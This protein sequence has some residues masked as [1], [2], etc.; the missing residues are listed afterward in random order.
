MLISCCIQLIHH[1][2]KDIAKEASELLILAFSYGPEDMTTDYAGALFESTKIALEETI[3]NEITSVIPVEGIVA[4]FARKSKQ[5]AHSILSFLL[6]TERIPEWGDQAVAVH[7][8]VAA[9]VTACPAAGIFHLDTLLEIPSLGPTHCR[10]PILT[11]YK[12]HLAVN[13]RLRGRMEVTIQS[14]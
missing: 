1:W 13:L 2:D 9:I 3:T 8:I 5:Y 10:T 11:P 4:V 6:C 12:S 14:N 7:R